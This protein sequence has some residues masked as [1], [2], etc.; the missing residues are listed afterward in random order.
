M[1]CHVCEG[2]F[3]WEGVVIIVQRS[4]KKNKYLFIYLINKQ[5]KLNKYKDDSL[6]GS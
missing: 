1:T 6:Y 4:M 5:M 3:A 2:Y